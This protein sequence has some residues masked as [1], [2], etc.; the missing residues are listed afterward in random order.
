MGNN[1]NAKSF[2]YLITRE[3]Q[4]QNI[5]PPQEAFKEWVYLYSEVIIAQTT[6]QCENYENMLRK[7]NERAQ[8]INSTYSRVGEL[9]TD[10][11]AIHTEDVLGDVYMSI[12]GG[13]SSFGQFFTPK[14][15]ANLAARISLTK[16]H[17]EEEIA[18]KGFI[19]IAE[20]C[21]GS[22]AMV[23]A[24]LNIAQ[25]YGVDISNIRLSGSDIDELCVRMA[26]I[27]LTALGA[28]ATLSWRN[29]F[30]DETY[31]TWETPAAFLRTAGA[32]ALLCNFAKVNCILE[33]IKSD[34]SK[35]ANNEHKIF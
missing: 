13:D 23:I 27:Q 33:K 29:S 15:V 26:L 34:Y 18:S 5:L 14:N 19:S 22:G 1:L 25:E 4:K 17:C 30:T 11:M 9:F 12:G 10:A 24:A 35:E 28:D 31:A 20:P 2:A 16:E 7:I 21:I 8:L 32:D 3:F 6:G